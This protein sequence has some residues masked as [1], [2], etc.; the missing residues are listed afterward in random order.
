MNL[1]DTLTKPID[2]NAL[3]G[4]TVTAPE[5]IADIGESEDETI[6]REV[7]IIM[8]RDGHT[9]ILTTVPVSKK[10]ETLRTYIKSA[11]KMYKSFRIYSEEVPI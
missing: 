5:D 11:R 7:N 9:E 6:V 10:D 4:M 2:F 3:V 8:D 1:L